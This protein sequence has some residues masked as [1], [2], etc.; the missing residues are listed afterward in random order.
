MCDIE[1]TK[2]ISVNG[3]RQYSLSIR[4]KQ[5]LEYGEASSDDLSSDWSSD[6]H[7][8]KPKVSWNSKLLI[9]LKLYQLIN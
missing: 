2:N 5:R 3:F 8:V 4:D 6:E 7:I 9:V 1:E